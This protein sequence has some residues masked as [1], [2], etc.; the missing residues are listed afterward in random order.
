MKKKIILLIFSLIV[1]FL[2]FYNEELYKLISSKIINIMEK[3]RIVNLHIVLFFFNLIILLTP[4]PTT[5]IYLLN[6]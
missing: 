6:V 1:L 5:F 3:E 2:V 4:F